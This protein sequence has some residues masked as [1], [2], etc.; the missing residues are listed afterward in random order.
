MKKRLV[1]KLGTG[2]LST[3]AG[4]SLDAAQFTRLAA[5]VATLQAEGHS[6]ILVSSAAI[7]GGICGLLV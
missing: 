5:E 7:A 6:C 1:I 3:P 2:V 4:K